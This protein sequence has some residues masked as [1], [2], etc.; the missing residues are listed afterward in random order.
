MVE[1]GGGKML[2]IVSL[3]D[4]LLSLGDTSLEDIMDSDFVWISPDESQEKAARMMT[5]YNLLALPV[6]DGEG[7]IVGIITVDD[8][9]EVLLPEPWL[10]RLP[11][12]FG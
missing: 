8:A 11:Q 9:M 2:G 4:L 1:E 7:R 6:L 3:R 10:K 5:D 12:V